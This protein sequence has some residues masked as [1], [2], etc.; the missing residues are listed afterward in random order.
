MSAAQC[1]A[2]DSYKF[3][4][5]GLEL[6]DVEN[7]VDQVVQGDGTARDGVGNLFLFVVQ[8]RVHQHFSHANDTCQTVCQTSKSF[9]ENEHSL[10]L[11]FKGV[12]SS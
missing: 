5:A 6:G 12:L 4:F 2:R 7:V 8:L 10:L 3:E 11:P 1:R 9:R